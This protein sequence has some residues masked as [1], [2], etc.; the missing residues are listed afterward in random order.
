[1]G[2]NWIL[3]SVLLG[4]STFAKA[5]DTPFLQADRDGVQA[6]SSS[7]VQPGDVVMIAPRYSLELVLAVAEHSRSYY[8]IPTHHQGRPEFASWTTERESIHKTVPQWNG[9]KVGSQVK[10]TRRREGGSTLDKVIAIV[11]TS[12]FGSPTYLTLHP[13]MEEA[14][15]KKRLDLNSTDCGGWTASEDLVEPVV[16]SSP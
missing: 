8:T 1:M 12:N 9:I 5:A 10:V 16:N 3:L 4:I 14:C 6:E 7:A 2:M 15:L 11:P 13:A